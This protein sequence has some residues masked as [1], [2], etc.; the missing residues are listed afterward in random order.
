M[1]GG[2]RRVAGGARV[3]DWMGGMTGG[4]T[5]PPPSGPQQPATQRRGATSMSAGRRRERTQ[6][7]GFSGRSPAPSIPLQFMHPMRGEEAPMPAPPATE[8]RQAPVRTMGRGQ[9]TTT[10]AW[11]STGNIQPARVPGGQQLRGSLGMQMAPDHFSHGSRR[12]PSRGNNAGTPRTADDGPV[13]DAR[14]GRRVNPRDGRTAA[15]RA[16]DGAAGGGEGVSI[17]RYATST[18][19]KA[20]GRSGNSNSHA[21]GRSSPR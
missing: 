6:P 17:S 1:Q 3:R 7:A 19:G 15:T 13:A 20:G 16:E 8:E 14:E 5:G 9:H 18:K 10:P 11:M 4:E 21:S 2:G 12:G